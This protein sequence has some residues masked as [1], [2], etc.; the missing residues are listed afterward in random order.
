MGRHNRLQ[1]A[2]FDA[3]NL[4]PPLMVS[5]TIRI[6]PRDCRKYCRGGILREAVKNPM[7]LRTPLAEQDSL[8]C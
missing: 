3:M 1:M 4:L 2:V 7:S 5:I 6:W 8:Y